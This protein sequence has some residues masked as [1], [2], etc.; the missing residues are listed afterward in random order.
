MTPSGL[1][2][3]TNA[4]YYAYLDRAPIIII[5]ATGP[6]DVSRRRPGIDWIH[7]SI[8][9]GEVVRDY[10]KWEH[11][12]FG[13][14]D[15]IDSFA[16]AYRVATQ[17]PQGP[18]YLCYDVGFQEDPLE[19]EFALPDPEKTGAGTH[20]TPTPPRSTSWPTGWSRPSSR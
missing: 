15:V 12:P 17:Q 16:R 14:G 3:A 11:Q 8:V 18:V 7:T 2:Q 9:Q 4:I 13:T 10:V 6:M 20:S 19:G 1:L 5:G